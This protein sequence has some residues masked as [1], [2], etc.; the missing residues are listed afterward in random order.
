MR[1]AQGTA[2][3]IL[4]PCLALAADV[5]LGEKALA[6]LKAR[7][8]GPATMGGRIAAIA[9][10]P[11]DSAT[12]YVGLGTGG[13]MKST[14]AGASFSAIFEKE[15]VAAI[16]AIAVA[17]SDA[18]VVWVGTGEANDRNSSSWGNG[19]YRSV[20]AGANFTNVG[21]PGSRVIAR[22]VVH[23]TDPKTAWVAV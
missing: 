9:L 21:L 3:V 7:A 5:P 20:D 15:K 23:P 11:S 18:K 10:D 12:F 8:I 22:I 1:A 17:P 16:G 13:V 2:F 4:V 19:I 6:A 14:N